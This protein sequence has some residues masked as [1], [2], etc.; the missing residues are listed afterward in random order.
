MG[1]SFAAIFSLLA[2]AV[3]GAACLAVDVSASRFFIVC[4]AAFWGFLVIG[5]IVGRAGEAILAELVQA[6]SA[7]AK[8]DTTGTPAQTQAAKTEPKSGTDA[9]KKTGA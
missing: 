9:P 7:L 6:K 1:R 5:Y 8:A 2:V 4:L 3:A